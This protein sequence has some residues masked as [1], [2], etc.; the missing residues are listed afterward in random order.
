MAIRACREH[1]IDTPSYRL[2]QLMSCFHQCH[3]Y[4]DSKLVSPNDDEV[5]GTAELPRVDSGQHVAGESIIDSLKEFEHRQRQQQWNDHLEV[6]RA[7]RHA[8]SHD[9]TRL[10]ILPRA[11]PGIYLR[12]MPCVLHICTNYVLM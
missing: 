4:S 2:G 5:I 11:V 6:E 10:P 8:V 7:C 12:E 3:L 9:R 1:I